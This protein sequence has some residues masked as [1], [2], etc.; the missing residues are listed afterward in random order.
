MK[1]HIA[2]ILLSFYLFSATPLHELLKFPMLVQHFM[3]HKAQNNQLS[4][5]SFLEM[6][7]ASGSSHDVSKGHDMKLPFK[8]CHC[9]HHTVI[10]HCTLAFLP[11]LCSTEPVFTTK[12]KQRIARYQFVFSAGSQCAIWQPPKFS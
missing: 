8:S 7:Y 9:S 5:F 11:N 10:L 6:H 12:T 1:K 3:E 4:F 2:L